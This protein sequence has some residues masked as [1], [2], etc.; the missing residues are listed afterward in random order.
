[1]AS[2]KPTLSFLHPAFWLATVFGVGRIP[3]APGTWGSLVAL[4]V[5][6]LVAGNFGPVALVFLA[7][8]FFP[9]GLWAASVYAGATQNIDPPSVV[10]DEV[11]AQWL[12]LAFVPQDAFFYGLGFF[13]FRIAD[14][15]KPW[16]IRQ[17]EDRFPNGFGIMA[18]DWLAALY[19]V[20]GLL[21]IKLLIG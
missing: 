6:W 9:I 13:L 17:F 5:A 15:L 4:P 14:I 7:F 10:I 11:V 18:D 19:A 1:M 20:A 16:P 2:E 8:L 21:L 3:F 12:V